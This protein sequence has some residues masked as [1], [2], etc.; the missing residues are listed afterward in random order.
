M[1]MWF[2]YN[3]SISSYSAS[4]TA[5]L[6][7]VT[8]PLAGANIIPNTAANAAPTTTPASIFPGIMVSSSHYD[9]D[10]PFYT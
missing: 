5:V 10:L 3:H 6:F 7:L 1:T 8:E 4:T 2:F 9:N